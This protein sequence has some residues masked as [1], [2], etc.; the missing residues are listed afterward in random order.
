M[1]NLAE[2]F[3]RLGKQNLKLLYLRKVTLDEGA[4]TA[5]QSQLLYKEAG[6][7]DA[8]IAVYYNSVATSCQMEN[9][10]AP[11]SFGPPGDKHHL[12]GI[13]RS[14]TIPTLLPIGNCISIFKRIS[15]SIRPL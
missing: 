14:I 10:L 1:V 5:L 6:R 15:E 4:F 7:L 9:K 11:E 12:F 2:C 13:H 8:L 3:H